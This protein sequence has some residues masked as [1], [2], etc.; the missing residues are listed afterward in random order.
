MQKCS[1]EIVQDL[2][3]AGERLSHYHKQLE[4]Y[5]CIVLTEKELNILVSDVV[6]LDRILHIVADKESFKLISKKF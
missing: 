4:L 1:D 6:K 2:K 5:N 3:M